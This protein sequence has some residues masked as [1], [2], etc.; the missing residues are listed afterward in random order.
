MP[1]AKSITPTDAVAV[2]NRAFANDPAAIA[3][4]VGI[5]IPCNEKMRDD[6]TIV[7]DEL[8][9]P[10]VG[11]VGLLNGLFG[12]EDTGSGFW[13]SIAV[14]YENDGG[15]PVGFCLTDAGLKAATGVAPSVYDP[16]DDDWRGLPPP[17]AR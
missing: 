14:R 17:E 9:D 10:V 8:Y 11:I 4:L 2:L 5:R 1:I 12:V 15:K 16:S 6:P 7:C 3:T 13:G